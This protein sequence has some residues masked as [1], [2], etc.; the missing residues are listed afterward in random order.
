MICNCT[1]PTPGIILVRREAFESI[2]EDYGY[3]EPFVGSGNDWDAWISLTL[4]GPI[5][6]VNEILMD[7]RQHLTESAI[8]PAAKREFLKI[9]TNAHA[10]ADTQKS[11]RG[12]LTPAA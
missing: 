11:I 7:W 4:R 5:A 1:I 12:A 8:E 2:K 10:I 6:F 9:V 3:S